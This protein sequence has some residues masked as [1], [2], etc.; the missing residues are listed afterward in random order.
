MEQL[1]F[2]DPLIERIKNKL[3]HRSAPFGRDCDGKPWRLEVEELLYDMARLII[4]DGASVEQWWEYET[5]E[6]ANEAV[7][8][9]L[10]RNF[11]GEPEGWRRASPVER[12]DFDQCHIRLPGGATQGTVRFA[13]DDGLVSKVYMLTDSEKR[14]ILDMQKRIHWP[15][16]AFDPEKTEL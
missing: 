6:Q 11:E 5:K 16:V 13:N 4:T 3:E 10:G 14:L 1:D 2:D 9:W 15:V 12:S 7:E 8:L